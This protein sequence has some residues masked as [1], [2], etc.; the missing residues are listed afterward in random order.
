MPVTPPHAATAGFAAGL[1][2]MPGRLL[3]DRRRRRHV[4]ALA[5]AG[6]M[7]IAAAWLP[8]RTVRVAADGRELVFETKH[9][10]DGALLRRAGVDLRPG[11]RLTVLD[12][13]GGDRVL[14]VERA[15]SVRLVVDGVVYDMRTHAVSIAQL[16]AENPHVTLEER[17]SVLQDGAFAS[18]NALLESP[19]LLVGLTGQSEGTGDDD[20]V[21]EVRRAVAFTVVENGRETRSTSSRPTIAQALREAGVTVGPGD[22]V[23]P[24]EQASLEANTRIDV[25]H[26]RPVTVALPHDH[27]VLYTL[28]ETVGE[29]LDAAGI[30]VPDDAIIDP[31]REVAIVAGMSVRVVQLSAGS[32]VEREYIESRTVYR[33]DPELGP[34]KIRTESGHDGVLVRR[35]DVAY[36]NGEEA[37]RTL[38]EE[39]YDPEPIDT[40]VYYPV[41]TGRDVERPAD[42]SYIRTLQVYATYYTPGSSG[43]AATDPAY[44]HTATGAIVT[45][46]IVAVDPRVIPLGTRMFIPGYGYAVA[47]DTGGAVKGNIIDLGYPDGVPID[48]KPGW[49]EIYILS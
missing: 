39:Y 16:I 18:V 23:T 47:A 9:S 11:D 6:A 41:Q 7:I 29:A 14:R 13:N 25:R 44:G 35:Y 40:V 12:G 45:Y 28:E 46:G 4:A 32:D 43:R 24:A 8:S 42:G 1:R 15:R 38:V 34:G 37:G 30:V 48:W 20:V 19:G 27:Q 36:V 2:S 26:A 33:S 10:N 21:I 22:V 31:P 3:R 49:I 5:V 17:D